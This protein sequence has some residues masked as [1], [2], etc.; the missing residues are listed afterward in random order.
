MKRTAPLTI[1]R[2]MSLVPTPKA[3]QPS[4][5][6]CGV[7]LSVPTTTWPGSAYCSAITACEMPCEPVL[8]ASPASSACK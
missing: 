6:E 3:T 5:P 1:A 7:W 4:A 8:P 2:A